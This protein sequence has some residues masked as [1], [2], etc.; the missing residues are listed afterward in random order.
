MPFVL[1]LLYTVLFYIWVLVLEYPTVEFS[2]LAESL[3]PK[4]FYVKNFIQQHNGNGLTVDAIFIIKT[5]VPG[6]ATIAHPFSPLFKLK[7]SFWQ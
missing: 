4:S 5:M 2:G 6:F 7:V 1:S 3:P